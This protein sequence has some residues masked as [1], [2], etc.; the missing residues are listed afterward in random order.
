MPADRLRA[1][2]VLVHG[3][4]GFNSFKI[5]GWEALNY[6]RGVGEF[7]KSKGNRVTAPALPPMAGVTERAAQLAQFIRETHPGE[8]VHLLAHSLGGLDSRYAIST[9]GL[10]DQVLS[11]TTL[12][13]PHQG[14]PVASTG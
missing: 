12:G 14:L 4:F 10:S 1:P 2:I 6:F 7:I 9:L 13:T 8:K 3:L 5:A 11:L